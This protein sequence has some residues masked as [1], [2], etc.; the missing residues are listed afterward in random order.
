MRSAK[1]TWAEKMANAGNFYADEN[2]FND[3]FADFY[4]EPMQQLVPV[5]PQNSG[6]QVLD[7]FL[8]GN[9]P[10]HQPIYEE[11]RPVTTE[12]KSNSGRH[13]NVDESYVDSVA[14]ASID[15]KTH[16]QT[17]WGVTVFRGKKF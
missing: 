11:L 10:N 8:Y 9:Q 16:K 2:V 15:P 17:R 14:D 13:K 5:D 4:E 6:D 1:L 12:A 7:N 3:A